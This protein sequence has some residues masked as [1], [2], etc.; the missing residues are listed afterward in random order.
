MLKELS[1]SAPT[2]ARHKG[3]RGQDVP[4]LDMEDASSNESVALQDLGQEWQES[5]S[6]HVFY[7][8][9]GFIPYSSELGH[10]LQR[11]W[12]IEGLGEPR[13]AH[14]S[15]EVNTLAKDVLQLLSRMGRHKV[16]LFIDGIDRVSTADVCNYAY[17]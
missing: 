13:I 4:L 16:V 15:P 14:T 8:F 17:L 5:S 3:R 10:I 7:H 6:W 9:V 11:V 12:G 2:P 1:N